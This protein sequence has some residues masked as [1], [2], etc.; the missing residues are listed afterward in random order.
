M[1]RRLHPTRCICHRKQAT[2]FYSRLEAHDGAGCTV[3]IVRGAIACPV[4][5]VRKWMDAG[6]ISNGPLFRAVGKGGRIS[7]ERLSDKQVA[8]TIKGY[9]ERLGLDVARFAGRSLRAGFLTSAA[10]KGANIFKMRKCLGIA[11][12][13]HC[14]DT[15]ARPNYSRIMLA[16]VCSDRADQPLNFRQLRPCRNISPPITARASHDSLRSRPPTRPMSVNVDRGD[17]NSRA[18]SRR[19]RGSHRKE[20]RAPHL[21]P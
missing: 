12:W 1:W 14:R 13:K 6:G 3:A 9:A 20:R 21:E 15:C 18:N 19:G 16:L 8:R 10:A 11:V 17:C 5:A 2:P 7:G 4:R